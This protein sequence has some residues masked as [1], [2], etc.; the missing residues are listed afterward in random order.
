MSLREAMTAL[1]SKSDEEIG[2]LL[3]DQTVAP[4][5]D[6]TDAL[7]GEASEAIELFS[8]VKD[9]KAVKK[10]GLMWYPMIRAG[11]HAVRPG[12]Q[13]QKV[14]RKMVVVEGHS[15]N[16]RKELGLQ[17]LLDA[18]NDDAIENVTVPT[19]HRNST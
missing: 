17:D 3:G 18:F 6:F 1:L 14:K 4:E 5:I 7:P 10:D 8:S 11:Q 19:S 2:A 12:P 9:V 16:A 15:E 13:G